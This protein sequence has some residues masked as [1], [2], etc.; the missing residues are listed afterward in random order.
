MRSTYQSSDH[1]R[2][3]A[4]REKPAFCCP[5]GGRALAWPV[6][7]RLA[8]AAAAARARASAGAISS[9]GAAGEEVGASAGASAGG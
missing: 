4:V 9:V 7:P 6:A 8:Q 5:V 1:R 2:A 3:A